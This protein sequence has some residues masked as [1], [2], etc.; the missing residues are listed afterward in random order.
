MSSFLPDLIV[1]QA[2]DK[3]HIKSPIDRKTLNDEVSAG[4]ERLYS[5]QHDDGGWG[6]WQDDPSLVFMTAY[7]VSG[8]GQAKQ[9][10]YTVDD[11]RLNNARNWLTSTLAAHPDMIPDLRAYTVYAL[12]TTGGAPKDALDRAWSSQDKL[13][14]EG[15]ALTGLAL[16]AAGDARAQQA[17]D[18]ARKEGPRDRRRC[19]LGG[20]VRRHD[21]F[22]G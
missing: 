20:H 10:G 17:A 12:A 14:D 5:Y 13:S 16:D 8:L 4:L 11:D 19:L 6:W 7:V 18:P 3:L 21:G 22:L 2:V 9:A 15:L 1:A